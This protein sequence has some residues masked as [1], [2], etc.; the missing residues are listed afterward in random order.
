MSE[1]SESVLFFKQKIRNSKIWSIVCLSSVPSKYNLFLVSE[2]LV[3]NCNIFHNFGI[4]RAIS[5][6]KLCGYFLMLFSN[7][8]SLF[9]KLITTLLLLWFIVLL[10]LI[11]YKLLKAFCLL[12]VLSIHSCT[13]VTVF[14]GVYR[15][16]LFAQ[17]LNFVVVVVLPMNICF[18]LL[19]FRHLFF[20]KLN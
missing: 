17:L 10:A 14:A 1:L 6:R 2:Y 5:N 9:D 16:T 12:M 18:F 20:L 3:F 7:F 8:L 13:F 15:F 4:F 19:L 11:S